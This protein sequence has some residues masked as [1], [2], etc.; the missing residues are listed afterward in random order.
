MTAA[1][2]TNRLSAALTPRGAVLQ[3]LVLLGL[4]VG[5]ALV[6]LGIQGNWPKVL[7]VLLAAL[8]YGIILWQSVRRSTAP[9]AAPYWNFVLAGAVAGAVSGLAR[10]T[11]SVLLVLVQTVGAAFLLASVHWLGVRAWQRQAERMID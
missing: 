7:R 6:G 4:V 9:G 3:S 8:A 5:G 11:T 10:S 1:T 2:A